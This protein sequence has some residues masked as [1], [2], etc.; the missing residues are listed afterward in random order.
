MSFNKRYVRKEMIL[1]KIDDVSYI[2]RLFNSDI[3]IMDDWSNNFLKNFNYNCES[4]DKVRKQLIDGVDYNDNYKKLFNL[5]NIFINLKTDPTLV[6]V[7]LT[8]DSLN[9]EIPNIELCEL[10]ESSI[11]LIDDYYSKK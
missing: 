2:F 8:Y 3:L 11:K 6:D 1:N 9:K 10:I 4:L 5:S 7:K